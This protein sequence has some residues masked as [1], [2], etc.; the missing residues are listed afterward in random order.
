MVV[1][2]L[3]SQ[4]DWRPLRASWWTE[5]EAHIIGSDLEGNFFLRHCDGTVRY[6][7]HKE[8]SDEV[9][10]TSVRNFLSQLKEET[11]D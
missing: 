5:K 6:W 3:I 9:V 1:V 2:Y 7:S 4:T 11:S 10:A 8:Q